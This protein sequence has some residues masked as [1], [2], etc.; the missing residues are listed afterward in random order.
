MNQKFNRYILLT[1]FFLLFPSSSIYIEVP[2][3][4]LNNSDSSNYIFKEKLLYSA[5]LLKISKKNGKNDKKKE[6]KLLHSYLNKLESNLFISQIKIGSDEQIF[7]LIFDTGSSILWIP[8]I[9]SED[10]DGQIEHHYNPKTSSTSKKTNHGYKIRYGS[11]YSLGYYYYDQ[12]KLFNY[13]DNNYSF[14]MNFG[15]ANK[16]KFKVEGADGIIGFG[17]EAIE[18]NYSSLYSLKEN[19][20]IDQAGFSIKYFNELKSAILYFGEEHEDFKNESI[21]FC[22]LSSK[23]YNEK[24]FWICEL[25]SF[26]ILFN[27]INSNINLNLS[28]AFDTGTNAI[29]L[30]KYILCFLKKQLKKLDC[31][32]N[33]ISLEINNIICYNKSTLPDFIFEVGDYYLRLSKTFLYDKKLLYN[34]T[35]IYFSNVYFE[36]GIEVGIIGLP[37]FYEFHTRFDL[38]NN[39]L[40]F[41]HKNN[42]N[43]AKSFNKN[44]DKDSDINYKLKVLIII[45][46]FIAFIL[47]TVI[48]IKYRHCFY[49]RKQSRNIENIEILTSDVSE[50]LPQSSNFF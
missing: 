16:T 19:K 37:F 45:L 11:G 15:V 3:K 32:I 36:E 4:L 22:P 8:G 42:K 23:T 7:N 30:P 41:Y 29:I 18:L 17:R 39:L 12:I 49:K 38:D 6:S 21:G 5:K 43:I 2:L 44:T 25:Y 9:G 28:L 20:Y 10:K 34:G 26:G 24:K 33:D 50:I 14:Y 13:S 35:E 46:S 27:E 40:K 48:I 47:I 31:S 1:T